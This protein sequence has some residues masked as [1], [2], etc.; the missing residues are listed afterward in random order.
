MQVSRAYLDAFNARLD[1][2][3]RAAGRAIVAEALRADLEQRLINGDSL[4]YE[5][6]YFT[7]RRIVPGATK[8]A[9]ALTCDFYDGLRD[10]ENIAGDFN[11]QMYESYTETQIRRTS[12]AI[13][14]EVAEGTNTRPLAELLSNASTRYTHDSV[15]KTIR[16]NTRRDPAKP[17][18]VIVPSPDACAFCI[19]RASNKDAIYEE[20]G[21]ESHDNCHCNPMP[22]FDK[23]TVE[24]YNREQYE[25]EY[26]NARDALKNGELPEDLQRHID[27]QRE[28]KGKGFNE[29]NAI[30]MVMRYQTGRK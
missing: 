15:E 17:K 16:D 6:V 29:T 8:L 11:A 13:A 25:K 9:A 2:V 12:Y 22:L 18:Y 14:K 24:G 30:L 5:D 21:A 3:N 19:M 7:M 10:A 23:S 20:S 1:A 28:E 26:E 4:A 27:K